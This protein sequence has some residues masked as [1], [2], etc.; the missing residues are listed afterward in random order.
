MTA[1]VTGMSQH[2]CLRLLNNVAVGLLE[3]VKQHMPLRRV[4]LTELTQT[5]HFESHQL[6]QSVAPLVPLLTECITCE[7]DNMM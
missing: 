7:T 6:R 3:D 5:L 4:W 1:Y 2:G